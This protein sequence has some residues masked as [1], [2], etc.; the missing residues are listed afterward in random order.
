MGN[1]KTTRSMTA[2]VRL[3]TSLLCLATLTGSLATQLRG[4][5]VHR[6][7]G[8]ASLITKL[9]EVLPPEQP[10]PPRNTLR[11]GFSLTRGRR[12][13]LGRFSWLWSFAGF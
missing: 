1:I 5:C 12:G 2:R 11:E 6:D 7:K 9:E 8:F 13:R 10:A 4:H 3:M